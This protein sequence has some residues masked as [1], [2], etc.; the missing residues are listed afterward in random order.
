MYCIYSRIKKT[1][2]KL[3]NYILK[4]LKIVVDFVDQHV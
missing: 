2:E 1:A 3:L 4:A